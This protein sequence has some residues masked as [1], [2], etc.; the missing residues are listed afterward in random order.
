MKP[1]GNVIK[2]ALNLTTSN[3]ESLTT[4]VEVSHVEWVMRGLLLLWDVGEMYY[5]KKTGLKKIV[6]RVTLLLVYMVYV[7]SSDQS[8]SLETFSEFQI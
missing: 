6:F 3:A 2:Y 4:F 8:E 7:C 5:S 1:D